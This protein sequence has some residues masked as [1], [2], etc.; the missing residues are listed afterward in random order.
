MLTN[1]DK[2][3]LIEG[4]LQSLK[5]DTEWGAAVKSLFGVQIPVNALIGAS[6]MGTGAILWPLTFLNGTDMGIRKYF[7]H[8]AQQCEGLDDLDKIECKINLLTAI[9]Q[10]LN[11][12]IDKC[13]SAKNPSNCNKRFNRYIKQIDNE[14]L[15]LTKIKSK[16][17]KEDRSMFN[18][19][20]KKT[21]KS[22]YG[23]QLPYAIGG[24]LL[25]AGAG[26]VS[27]AAA[28]KIY[29]LTPLGKY[30]NKKELLKNFSM[31]GGGIGAIL[32]GVIGQL[33]GLDNS[34][35]K[36]FLQNAMQCEELSKSDSIICKTELLKNMKIE[37]VKS[38]KKCKDE[39]CIRKFNFYISRIENELRNLE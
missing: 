31:V 37:L 13:V 30:E 8:K 19:I 35:K 38:S 33:K 14:I 27:G 28:G 15:Q 1:K 18:A 17:L 12:N 34:V 32:G 25:G 2:Q 6:G 11:K 10:D 36:Y 5:E 24:G 26:L 16:N 39:K 22:V 20:N 29:G 23:N 7:L 21:A 9:K 3:Y 4:V